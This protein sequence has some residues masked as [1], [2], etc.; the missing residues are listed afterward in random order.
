MAKPLKIVLAINYVDYADIKKK[1]WQ[2]TAIDVLVHNAPQN[3]MLISCNSPGERTDLPGRFRVFE[4]LERNSSD[5]VDNTRPL[6]YVY[7]VLDTCAQI[8]CD[9]FGYVNSDI[10]L[11]PK[12]F[13]LFQP[14][15]DAYG[16]YKRDI[17]D[18]D[19]KKLNSGK[20]HV[21]CDKPDGVDGFFFN[22]VWWLHNRTLFPKDLILGETEW[23]TC[24]NT[25]LQ[26]ECENYFIARALHHT[27]HDRIWDLDSP[28]AKNNIKIW[29]RV[30]AKYGLPLKNPEE[31]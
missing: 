19:V 5:I 4:A 11:N 3:V 25:I 28:G 27:Y 30:R 1:R 16:F 9:V 31:A 15:I 18:V 29:D 12:F 17:E 14:G 2:K 10:L 23:D 6:P 13:T 22:R 26:K 8:K 24:Y 21:V 20:F 7:D